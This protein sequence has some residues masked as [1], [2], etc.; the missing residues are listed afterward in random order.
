MTDDRL[1]RRGGSA[2]SGGTQSTNP[3]HALRISLAENP[4][5]APLKNGAYIVVS[6]GKAAVPMAEEALSL[7]T[8][9]P[10]KA[11]VVTNYA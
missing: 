4:I 5:E 11:L 9:A 6:V 10:V 8:N 1:A 7:L 3:A 2:V